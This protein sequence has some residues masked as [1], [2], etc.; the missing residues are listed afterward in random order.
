MSSATL[1]LQDAF[2][3][4][5]R[6]DSKEFASKLNHYLSEQG[7]EVWFDFDD[8]PL[9]V[10]YQNQINSGIEQADNFLFIISPH[11][12]NS[13]YCAREIELALSCNK[14][15]IPLLHVEEISY[16]TW[17]QRNLDANVSGWHALKEKGMHSSFPNMHTAISKINWV[18]FREGI[19]QFDASL[20]GLETILARHQSYV[21][22]HTQLLVN[23]LEWQRQQRQASYLLTDTETLAEADIWLKT[24]FKDAQPPCIPTDLHCEFITESLKAANDQM[25]QIFISYSEADTE[26]QQTLRKRMIREGI[27]TWVN[28][29]DIPTAEDFQSAINRGIEKTDNVVLLLSSD[30][31][32]SHYCQQE[33]TYARRYHKRIIPLLVQSMDVATLPADLRMLQ[34]VDFTSL[35][36]ATHF[37]RAVDELVR[38]LH[39]AADYLEQHKRLLVKALV[40]EQQGRDR[41]FLLRSDDFAAAKTWLST[42]SP[43]GSS[44]TD[45]HL[46]YIEASQG[47][48]QF[49]DIFISYGRVDSKAFAMKLYQRLSQQGFQVWFDQNDIP[50][51]V[52]FQE[53]INDGIEKSHN[54]IIILGPHSVNSPYCAKEISLALKYNKRIIPILHVE[55]ISYATWQTRNPEG[56]Q[57]QWQAYKAAGKHSS[58]PNMHPGIS[59]INWLNAREG[60]DDL[61]AAIE[62]LA[63]LCRHHEDYVHQHT[64]L[65]INALAW[66]R[67]QNQASYLLMGEDRI[68]AQNWLLTEFTIEQ[69]PCTPS[70]VQA[71]FITESVKAADGGM[72]QVFISYAE[73]D[74]TTKEIVRYH[75]LQAGVTVWTNTV[76]IRMGEDFEVAIQRGLEEADNIVY[77]ISQASLASEYCQEEIYQALDLNKRVIPML[78]EEVEL[79][80]IPESIRKIQFINLT[81]NQAF[82]DLEKDMAELL[83]AIQR[84][85]PYH[86]QHKRLLV[87]ALKWEQQ[88]QNP[89]LLLQRQ[90]LDTY[91]AWAQTAK[92]RTLHSALP[93]QLAFL[94]ASQT[95]SPDQTLG[96]FFI[97]HIDDIDFSQRLNETLLVQGKSAWL[98]P[99]GSAGETDRLDDTHQLINNS[100]TVLFVL[101]PSS[102]RCQ[103]CLNQ[104][105]YAQSQHKRI[106]PV[107][108]RDVVKS[109]LPEGI[110]S[111]TWSDFRRHD[112]NFLINFGELFRT[113]E[114]D[115][116]HVRSH[117]RLLVKASEWDTAQ[118]DESFLLRGSD[119]AESERWL[120]LANDKTP[121]VTALQKAYIKASQ[122][123]PFKKIKAPSVALATVV[124]ALAISGIRLFGGFQSLEIRAYDQFLRWR[125]DEVEQ[126]ERL[127]IVKVDAPSGEWLRQQMIDGRYQPGIGTIP[128]NAL[129]DA[130]RVL[131]GQGARLIGL[132][133]FRDFPAQGQL[134]N[135]LAQT[136]NLFGICQTASDQVSDIGSELP[137]PRVGFGNFPQDGGKI[138]RR[139]ALVQWDTEDSACI[140]EEAFTLLLARTYLNDQG[141][142]SEIVVGRDEYG[143]YI[144]SVVVGDIV[145]PALSSGNGTAYHADTGK[146]TW[147]NW[148]SRAWSDLDG[149]QT[150]LNF[151][152]YS[153]PNSQETIGARLKDFA[154]QVSLKDVIENKV[155]PA[156]IKD[157]IVLIGY[158]DF[159]DRNSDDFNTPY[160][161]SVPGVYL[162]GQMITQLVNAVLEDRPLIRWWPFIGEAGWILLWSSVGGLI[163]WR[164]VRLGPVLFASLTSVGVL[165]L[166][167][168]GFMVGPV[169]WVPWMPALIGWGVS[170]SA[171]GYMTYRLRKG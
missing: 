81:D 12:V 121:P 80:L 104:L 72:T 29:V 97:H 162:H 156:L 10:N 86:N 18:Y 62:E 46:A 14:R 91:L 41:K 47:V 130:I 64:E 79:T 71:D 147:T 139:H 169:I 60:V 141:I 51:G 98:S 15:I 128:E 5:G 88:R 76:D 166:V 94:E 99:E 122:A 95:Q 138:I 24:R 158:T 153:D 25:T 69:P 152:T 87:R 150:L 163:F 116:Y 96:V 30:S 106:L 55:E 50:L 125:P 136:D 23:A 154:Q 101:S 117:T 107:I 144:D 112:N 66:E 42:P 123:L 103:A 160:G 146:Q 111:L 93:L 21:R 28:T 26:I 6:A 74:L 148:G 124:T 33:L 159:S 45:L 119:L 143:E 53:Q 140:A 31:L 114:S 151:W 35:A 126:D 7:L 137:N 171:V 8:I 83:R 9:G 40:W 85:A 131:N 129:S 127:L 54:F 155:D 168:Y 37:D 113:L 133:F 82:V 110:E 56:T 22:Q 118:Q 4:Y 84:D 20:V 49:Y 109:T 1:A 78:V 39:T 13:P 105:A 149:A 161:D 48:N 38:A 32:T 157:R 2:I 170:S 102:V 75:L 108:Y 164:F 57:Q 16:E 59:K 17:Q 77:L 167:C 27:T 134:A 100:E 115:P 61:T 90:M 3:S 70:L 120:A 19:D 58:F 92:N 135:D 44:P 68:R 89:S 43:P 73:E 34:F 165:T 52:D 132:D 63:N 145:L 67:H 142:T 65:L 36:S 11:A